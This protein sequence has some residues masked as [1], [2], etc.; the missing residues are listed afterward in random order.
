MLRNLYRQEFTQSLPTIVF[1]I[2]FEQSFFRDKLSYLR[3]VICK[4]FL[5]I[6]FEILPKITLP[7]LVEHG[8]I[9]AILLIHERKQVQAAIVIP[10][11]NRLKNRSAE[12]F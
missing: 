11:V 7:H 4:D 2:K 9:Q 5:P 10:P 12:D 3:V 1:D 6:S 8:S